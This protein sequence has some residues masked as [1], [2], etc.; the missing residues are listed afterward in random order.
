MPTKKNLSSF[1]RLADE[2]IC[3]YVDPFGSLRRGSWDSRLL[4]CQPI[5]KV[6]REFMQKH[7]ERGI[8]PAKTDYVLL[9]SSVDA[10]FR[11][12]RYYVVFFPDGS[13]AAEILRDG[14]QEIV[15]DSIGLIVEPVARRPSMAII[16]VGAQP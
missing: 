3:P 14:A 13:V 16:W 11:R 6:F 12:A 9:V 5:Y 4:F 8:G 1:A 2:D 15:R 7:E 10:G